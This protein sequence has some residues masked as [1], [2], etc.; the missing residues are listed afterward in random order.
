MNIKKHFG[1]YGVILNAENQILLVQKSRGEYTGLLDLPGGSVEEYDAD[2]LAT[3]KREILEETGY[4]CAETVLLGSFLIPYPVKASDPAY[5]LH[6]SGVHYK[7][8][9]NPD[10]RED[11]TDPQD[12]SHL[13]WFSLDALSFKT[14]TPH[15][16]LAI[17]YVNTADRNL[18][19]AQL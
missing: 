13:E 2:N 10:T 3:L 5:T 4:H 16:Q 17:R 18:Y 1:I 6:H 7:V 8:D 15:A 9:I 11:A 12:V 14:L 19:K